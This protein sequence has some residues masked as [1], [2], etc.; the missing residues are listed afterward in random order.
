LLLLL[1]TLLSKFGL[2]I[3]ALMDDRS[4]SLR[5]ALRESVRQTE[6][7]EFF[8]MLFLIKSALVGYGAYWLCNL[9]LDQLWQHGLMNPRLDPYVPWLISIAVAAMLES[10]LFIAF[11][12]LYSELN[13][14]R[15]SA[16][17]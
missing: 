8:F 13:Q 4:I 15:D 1:A 6:H 14:P 3:P 2:T 16:E 11:S 9:A 17:Q 12:V 7:W 5:Q 10:P